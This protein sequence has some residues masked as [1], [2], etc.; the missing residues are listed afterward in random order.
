MSENEK[1]DPR[2]TRRL[3]VA[4]VAG[5]VGLVAA[6]VAVPETAEAQYRTGITDNDPSDGPGRGRGGY[7]GGYTGRTDRDPYDGPGR[8]RY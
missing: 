3:L 1:K 6:T 7:R 5:G 2:L 8:G 4:K